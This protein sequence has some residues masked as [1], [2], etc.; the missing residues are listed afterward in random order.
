MPVEVEG[1]IVVVVG[2]EGRR[3]GRRRSGRMVEFG[4]SGPSQED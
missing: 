4:N 2:L 3:D 1:T